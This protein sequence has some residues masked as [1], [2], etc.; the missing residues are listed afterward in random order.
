MIVSVSA[1]LVVRKNHNNYLIEALNS[2]YA[3]S[4]L[5][6]EVILILGRNTV[7][8]KKKLKKNIKI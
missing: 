5:P 4:Y 3:Q 7:V 6:E 2:V 8:N 1:I